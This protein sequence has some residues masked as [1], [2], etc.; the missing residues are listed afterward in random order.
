MCGT[1]RTGVVVGVTTKIAAQIDQACQTVWSIEGK[2]MSPPSSAHF[3]EIFEYSKSFEFC[4]IN[5]CG[6]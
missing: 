3:K 4:R 2:L 6:P 1:A 5:L